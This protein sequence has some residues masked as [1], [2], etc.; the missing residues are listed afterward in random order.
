MRLRALVTCLAA[1]AVLLP[2]G[3]E[4]CGP[5]GGYGRRRPARRL[6]P[7][8][9]KQFS[10]GVAEKAPGASGRSEGKISRRS[11]RFR[12]LAPNYNPDIVFK[13]EENTGADRMMTQRCKDRLNSL[14]ISVMNL[15]PSVR[16]RVTEGWD[17][18]GH[19]AEESLHYEGR[20]VDLTTS[21][22]DRAKYATLARLAVE[23]GFDWV[24]YESKAHIHCS[25]KSDRAARAQSLT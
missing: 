7:L 13:D 9:Y 23:A 24:H 5:G 18:D 22:R 2:P 21:D 10:P 1:C 11:A 19:H 3:R 4:G 20:A 8:A 16:V 17:E 12:E 15:W 6:P 25:V 14:A